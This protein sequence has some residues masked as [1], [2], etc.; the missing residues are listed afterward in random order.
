VREL[1]DEAGFASVDR[2]DLHDPFNALYV[3]RS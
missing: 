2:L 3:V 1:C